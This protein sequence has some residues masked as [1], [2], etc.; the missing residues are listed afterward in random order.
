MEDLAMN[1][2]RI[3]PDLEV[4]VG[5]KNAFIIEVVAVTIAYMIAKGLGII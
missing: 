5:I 1:K 2:K 4:W 3:N